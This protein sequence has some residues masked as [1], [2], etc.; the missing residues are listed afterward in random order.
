MPRRVE[1][2]EH[3]NSSEARELDEV[4]NLLEGVHLP[5]REGGLPRQVGQHLTLVCE[6]VPIHDVP[7]KDI[8]L[9]VQHGVDVLPKDVQGQKVARGVNKQPSESEPRV[10]GD[11]AL[12]DGQG[13]VVDLLLKHLAEGFQPPQDAHPGAG[14]QQGRREGDAER[15]ILGGALQVHGVA[16]GCRDLDPQ[17]F[18][19]VRAVRRSH[20]A[21]SGEA[22]LVVPSHGLVD[23]VRLG[24]ARTVAPGAHLDDL[25]PER[26]RQ[27]ATLRAEAERP[28]QRPEARRPQVCMHTGQQQRA[29][30]RSLHGCRTP[31]RGRASTNALAQ[32]R[33]C[34]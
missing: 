28:G 29:E 15:V 6:G 13:S 25:H 22:H 5:L 30:H 18:K 3:S 10:V 1:L 9:V 31:C 17:G 8:H 2:R 26:G 4:G 14:R 16:C 21:V 12:Q 20:E 33:V 24:A 19:L 32:G 23:H 27:L 34:A 11:L 7:M